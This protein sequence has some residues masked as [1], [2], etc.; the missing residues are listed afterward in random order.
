MAEEIPNHELRVKVVVV[1]AMGQAGELT[2][3]MM[4]DRHRWHRCC[5]RCHYVLLPF[6]QLP[7]APLP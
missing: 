4:L 1:E 2:L 5:C 7:A 6:A 3:L